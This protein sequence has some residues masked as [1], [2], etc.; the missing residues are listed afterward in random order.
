[1]GRRK[2]QILP[3]QDDRNRAV[4]FQ[5]RKNGL[6]KKAYELSVLCSCDVA[7]IVFNQNGKLYQFASNGHIDDIML[8]Y[9]DSKEAFESRGPE[10]Y[11]AG[12][13]STLLT[14]SAPAASGSSTRR[15][16][17]ARLAEASDGSDGEDDELSDEPIENVSLP[18][19]QQAMAM[20]GLAGGPSYAQGSP[21][22]NDAIY[23]MPAVGGPQWNNF[24]QSRGG[25][26]P[27]T[28]Q[29]VHPVYAQPNQHS[30]AQQQQY[31]SYL[32][33]P[34]PP[35]HSLSESYAHAPTIYNRMPYSGLPSAFGSGSAPLAGPAGFGVRS[36]SPRLSSLRQPEGQQ[37]VSQQQRFDSPQ[38]MSDPEAAR[39]DPQRRPLYRT[40]SGRSDAATTAHGSGSQRES[41]KPRLSLDIPAENASPS[42]ALNGI[43]HQ[44]ATDEMLSDG[45]AV[46]T[47][48]SAS[49]AAAAIML[50]TEKTPDGDARYR[51]AISALFPNFST[52]EDLQSV[53]ANSARQAAA[54]QHEE[55]QGPSTEFRWPSDAKPVAAE[56]TEGATAEGQDRRKRPKR[57]AT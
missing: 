38:P 43:R 26:Q 31:S 11:A 36:E 7:V 24:A 34:P 22:A 17:R 40:N 5:K 54:E 45:A 8:H 39:Q 3:L 55:G 48:V 51:E 25:Q 50:A 42:P 57:E 9:A 33:R 1:M 49:T 53:L 12:A 27:Y 52:D 21:F 14:S 44:A 15:N 2:I 56:S 32:S 13:Q 37:P 10:D 20:S 47:P 35:P 18:A 23:A 19:H 28:Q 16:T 6:M 41:P 30:Q 29:Q 46:I 4:T